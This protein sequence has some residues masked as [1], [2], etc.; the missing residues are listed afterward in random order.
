MIVT[1][2]LNLAISCD[3]SVKFGVSVVLST[4]DVFG[5]ERCCFIALQWYVMLMDHLKCSR[6][7]KC[8]RTSSYKVYA[9]DSHYI[10][11]Q[12]YA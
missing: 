9:D 4:E 11:A 2:N 8:S 12:G 1:I 3:L 5:Q 10:Q 7:A 6:C